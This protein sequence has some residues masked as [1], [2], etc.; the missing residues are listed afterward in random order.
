MISSYAQKLLQKYN[1]PSIPNITYEEL[2]KLEDLLKLEVEGGEGFKI[3]LTT[4]KIILFHWKMSAGSKWSLHKHDCKESVKI[5]DG[6]FL[7]NGIAYGPGR[8]IHISK[9]VPHEFLTVEDG[10]FY[11]EFLNPY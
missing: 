1:W 4:T 8:I 7:Y 6:L 11:V 3:P 9:N 2:A 5:I 10:E